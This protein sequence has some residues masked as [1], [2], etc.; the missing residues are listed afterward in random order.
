[1]RSAFVAQGHVCQVQSPKYKAWL[2]LAASELQEQQL[3]RRLWL[4]MP[5]PP[6][7][8]TILVGKC[9]ERRDL[10]NFTKVVCDFLVKHE[11]IEDDSLKIVHEIT[12]KKAFG[13]VPDGKI[14]INIDYC[15]G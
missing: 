2:K 10:D 4:R 1:M 8:I 15:E 11:F 5:P 3:T 12:V 13:L 7:E 9:N 14:E 6:Y